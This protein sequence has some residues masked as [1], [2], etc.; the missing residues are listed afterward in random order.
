MRLCRRHAWIV[1]LAA[2]TACGRESPSPTSPSSE[3]TSS[4]V[5]PRTIPLLPGAIELWSG[6][7][8]LRNTASARAMKE[9][10]RFPPHRTRNPREGER[11]SLAF[12][13]ASTVNMEVLGE[14]MTQAEGIFVADISPSG[15]A[16]G[17]LGTRATAWAS[18]TISPTF[19][20]SRP[21][22]GEHLSRANGIN[23]QGD[24]V[25]MVLSTIIEPGIA[26][27]ENVRL[28]R[29]GA[30]GSIADLP[31]PV[32]D[33]FHYTQPFITDAGEI[34]ATI[35][36]AFLGPYQIA[37]WHNGVPEIVATPENLPDASVIDVS[38]SGYLLAGNPS[39]V[40][41]VRSPNG[42]WTTLQL[43]TSS[44][45][46]GARAVTEA[47]E[48]LGVATQ[49]DGA[50][51]GARWS[52][53]GN[54]MVDPLPAGL[55]R[56]LYLAR[57]AEGRFAA[58][59]CTTSGCSF[60]VLD[61]GDATPLPVPGFPG[62]EGAFEHAFFGGLS[63]TDQA[64]GW[65]MGSGFEVSSGVRWTLDFVSPDSD[66]DG[67]P[68]ATDNCPQASNA[69]QADADGDGIGDAC[70]NRAPSA[71]AG[72]QYAGTEGSS[73]VF[74]GTAGDATPT[75]LLLS[76]WT[77]SDGAA[78]S[79]LTTTHAFADNGNFSARL[80]VTDGEFTA[81]DEATVAVANAAPILSTG[82]GSTFVAGTTHVLQA[83]FADPGLLDAPWSYV[84]NWGDGTR[85]TMGNTAM[86]GVLALPHTYKQAGVF[87]I[88][89]TVTD[90]DG[91]VGAGGY[92][93]TVTKRGGR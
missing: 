52:V 8:Q 54:A 87:D 7:P 31:T 81:T 66:N 50:Q 75:G 12:A 72:G 20:P 15:R 38:R 71:S 45:A 93:V 3:R 34:Y 86:A 44:V 69:D 25:G 33:T 40:F 36:T 21:E 74:T 91:G 26:D 46:I 6:G 18:T 68:D 62:G 24:I 77:F 1:V 67:I 82:S 73:V 4:R 10:F 28:V 63:G 85:T 60:Y 14:G 27:V 84:V 58:E 47:G 23:T 83:Q 37:R 43:P 79:G 89:V 78:G 49:P 88:N 5:L 61:Q 51:H 55:T 92:R 9:Q 56:L 53:D 57:N 41:A 42:S 70:D 19:L 30:D 32:A 22:W 39:Q 29:W 76:S 48:A 80:S 59:G 2:I 17:R 64:V 65:Y 35:Q 90:K 16:V 11:S 13:L